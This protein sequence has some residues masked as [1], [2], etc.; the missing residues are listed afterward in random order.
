MS[1]V[2]QLR[3]ELKALNAKV[4]GTKAELI[5]RLQQLKEEKKEE[6]REEKKEETDDWTKECKIYQEIMSSKCADGAVNYNRSSFYEE[7]VV[8]HLIHHRSNACNGGILFVNLGGVYMSPWR[9]AL[10]MDCLT[11][12]TSFYI[13][14]NIQ[15]F[16]KGHMNILLIEPAQRT[17]EWFEPHGSGGKYIPVMRANVLKFFESNAVLFPNYKLVDPLEYCPLLG[18]QAISGDAMCRNWSSLYVTLRLLCSH[19]PRFVLVRHLLHSTHQTQELLRRWGCFMLQYAT[20]E[21]ITAV[22]DQQYRIKDLFKNV[23]NV[24]DQDEVLFETTG[25]LLE[26]GH[27]IPPIRETFTQLESKYITMLKK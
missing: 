20:K 3:K 27:A 4:G 22:I 7:E 11:R 10:W 16:G 18:W 9:R 12:K 15:E 1:T 23:K 19:V 6:K 5:L 17:I 24:D 2:R 21:G 26:M 8:A 13:T 14:L 25:R